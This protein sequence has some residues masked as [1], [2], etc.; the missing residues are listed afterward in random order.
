MRRN[1]S[2]S[3]RKKRLWL[4][5][6]ALSAVLTALLQA[7]SSVYA[8][9]NPIRPPASHSAAPV[10]LPPA[11]GEPAAKQ[12]RKLPVGE[13]PDRRTRFSSTRFNADHTFTTTTSVHP[14]NYRVANGGWQP[15]DNSLGTSRQKGYAYQNGANSFQAQFKSQLGDD[16]LRWVVDGQ[17][18]SMSLQGASRAQGTTKGSSIQYPSALTH[19]NASYNVVGEG[20]EEVL[21]LRDANAQSSFQFLLKTPK[22]TTAS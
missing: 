21:E 15:I 12:P 20:L 2:R 18:V 10:K 9:T 22:G 14:V 16:Y 6:A 13:Q 17:P 19:V 7:P 3:G 4:A 11:S 8:A 5:V 1:T